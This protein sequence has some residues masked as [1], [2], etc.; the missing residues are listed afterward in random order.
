MEL[1]DYISK[2][3][4][5]TKN[6]GTKEVKIAFLSNFTINGL[7]E[8]MKV[9]CS[10][11]GIYAEIYTSPYNQYTQ[12]I[13]N[14]S[15]EL[16]NLKPDIIFILLDI[17]QFLGDFYY[18]PYRMDE[19]QKKSF[20][21]KKYEEIKELI[22]VLKDSINAKVVL[23]N[24][25]VPC[26]S[27]RGIF[28]NKQEFGFKKAVQIFNDMLDSLALNNSQLFIFDFNSF[29][30][31]IGYENLVDSKM[32][33]L[34]DMKI[35]PSALVKVGFEYMAYIFPLA[36]MTKKCLVLDLDNT[37]WGGI[38]G[39]D[40]LE[41]IKL[42]PE[43]E[44]RPF[45]DFQKRILE[46]SERGVILAINSKNNYDDVMEVMKNHKYM[47]LKEDNFACMKINWQD[48]AT[49][50]R[51]IAKEL[52]IGLDSLVFLDDDETNRA[53]I[54]ELIPEVTVIDLPKDSSLYPK[55]IENLKVFN[56]FNITYD[57][58]IRGKMYTDQKKRERLSSAV[59]DV[60]S[61]IKQLKIRVAIMDAD[62]FNIPRI[63]QLTQKTNQFNVTTKRYL[64]EDIKR[65]SKSKDYIIKCIQAE[66]KF[67]DYGTTGVVIV[68]RFDKKS[69]WEIDTFLLSC[70]ILGKDI[71]FTLMQD[72][73]DGAKRES[74]KEIHGKFIP[75]KKNKPAEKFFEDCGFRLNKKN[76][77]EKDY[78]LRVGK[79]K[80]RNNYIKVKKWK[81]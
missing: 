64:E 54:R 21:K 22:T 34:G 27:S 40:G 69:S 76:V 72:I 11:Q 52:N 37:L 70:R 71:E 1:N 10:E 43:K 67:G 46:L 4:G 74:I 60:E 31:K 59:K 42:G 19:K 2:S 17:E 29:C 26:Y 8:T 75:T 3:R 57:D 63:A 38:I 24:L 36:S 51:E 44:G 66:D 47:I 62:R 23:N 80:K 78:V 39:E 18:F 25:S 50:M 61:F 28:E 55:I 41:N 49:N 13:L 33:Y 65:F 77:E 45:L 81:A 79:E 5:L 6:K 7:A 68:K 73:I 58:L 16:Y 15:S 30:S 35:S 20:I 32:Y 56:V 14:K 12:E 53:M 48:K 9:L